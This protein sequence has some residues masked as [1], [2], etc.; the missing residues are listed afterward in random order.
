[1]LAFGP[2]DFTAEDIDSHA[3][4]RVARLTRLEVM[5]DDLIDTV[6]SRARRAVWQR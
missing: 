4:F 2:V 1:L 3:H 5:L 6:K